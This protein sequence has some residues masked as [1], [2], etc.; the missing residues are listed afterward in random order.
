MVYRTFGRRVCVVSFFF[1]FFFFL[2]GGGGGGRNV[3]EICFVCCW[4]VKLLININSLISPSCP[5]TKITIKED[6]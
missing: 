6:R 4:Q 2:G 1:L 3:P 5:E